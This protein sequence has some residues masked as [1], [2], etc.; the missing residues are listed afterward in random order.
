LWPGRISRIAYYSVYHQT[1]QNDKKSATDI[2]RPSIRSLA[3]GVVSSSQIGL[4][5]ALDFSSREKMT[6]YTG[7]L[8]AGGIDRK[9]LILTLDENR[10]VAN[11]FAFERQRV[12]WF[13]FMIHLE[14]VL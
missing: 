4:C 5:I 14:S 8:Q 7:R 3:S 6:S 2:I 12:K 1:S 13:S 9:L 11:A 10:D